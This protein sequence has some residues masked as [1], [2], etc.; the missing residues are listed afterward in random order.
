MKIVLSVLIWLLIAVM[1][2]LVFLAS[3]F[4]AVFLYPFDRDRKTVHTFGYWWADG[5]LA[6]NPFWSLK[7]TGLENIDPH[8]TY[9]I[10]ANHQSL[11]DIV[12]LYKTRMQF[13]WIAKD[14]LFS[15]PFF[16]WNLSLAKHVKVARAEHGSIKKAYD[17]AG[18]W[19]K[20][21]ISVLFFPEGTRSVTNEL[22]T[23]KNGAFKLA[24]QEKKPILPVSISG[25]R[26]IIPRGGLILKKVE[27]A[28]I[29]KVLPAIETKD[30]LPEDFSRLRDAVRNKLTE[31]LVA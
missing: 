1:S 10:V 19:L 14:S 28:C 3:S 5:I 20:K 7:V 23:F 9:V 25:T 11:F 8:K 31:N 30:L 17:E 26:D 18:S 22:N 27:A 29:L 16:G 24:I 4:M 15:V 6:A 2:I 13:K 12:L 21:G